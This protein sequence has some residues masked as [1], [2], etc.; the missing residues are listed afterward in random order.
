MEAPGCVEAGWRKVSN[1]EHEVVVVVRG[2]SG[3]HRELAFGAR[4]SWADY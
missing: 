3:K 1:T 2:G 4:S